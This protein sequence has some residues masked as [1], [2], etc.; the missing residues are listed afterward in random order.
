MSEKFYVRLTVTFFDK[1]TD[2]RIV[3]IV[4]AI[5]LDRRLHTGKPTPLPGVSSLS[6]TTLREL[7]DDDPQEA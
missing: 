3:D 7:P 6:Y 5:K 1:S 4:D 2:D